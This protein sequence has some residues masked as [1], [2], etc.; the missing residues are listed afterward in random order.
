MCFPFS[1]QRPTPNPFLGAW[2]LSNNLLTKLYAESQ[3]HLQA[4]L[5]SVDR[6]CITICM[7]AWTDAQKHSVIVF[8]VLI[9]GHKPMLLEALD[10]SYDSHTAEH[11]AHLLKKHVDRVGKNK[12]AAI[13]TDNPSANR[14]A[15]VQVV[16]MQGYN[17][18]LD[19]RCM[20]H[21]FA[22]II[23][24]ITSHPWAREVVVKA[25]RLITFMRA[26]HQPL[27][28]LR[29]HAAQVN[30]KT[31]LRQPNKTRFTSL[32]LA[33]E[34]L[35]A[36]QPAF[37]VFRSQPD[38]FNTIS[39]KGADVKDIIR[40]NGF[41]DQAE[42]LLKVLQPLSQVIMAVQS[43]TTILADITR[44]WLYLARTY[45]A[46]L[47][48]MPEHAAGF[49]LHVAEQYNKRA[50]ELASPLCRL[51]LFL[52]PRYRSAAVAASTP[53][54]MDEL[55]ITAGKIMKAYGNSAAR[56]QAALDQMEDYTSARGVFGRAI[57]MRTFNLS[58]WWRSVQDTS[59]EPLVALALLLAEVVPHA[60]SPECVFSTMGWFEGGRRSSL[61]NT[62]NKQLTAVKMYLDSK[63]PAKQLSEKEAAAAEARRQRAMQVPEGS[64]EQATAAEAAAKAA[65]EAAAEAAAAGDEGEWAPVS[66]EE[67]RAGLER[68]YAYAQ[69]QGDPV[70]LE[71][72]RSYTE[73]LL[74]NWDGFDMR[75]AVFEHCDLT[76]TQ[77]T[78]PSMFGAGEEG[79]FDVEVLVQ[80][81]RG[82]PAAPAPGV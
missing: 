26:S 17:H 4:T 79:D 75:A 19:L 44:Y 61:S 21:G 41:W 29:E 11:L 48:S 14:S 77:P 72:P 24:N 35:L 12:V 15:R 33:L 36:L 52:D 78:V 20:M 22:L 68:M 40:D 46:L 63:L 67:M 23:G 47:P 56:V 18:I 60:A 50:K 54:K 55:M 30:I 39:A 66:A 6:P 1:Q 32:C 43:T 80:S 70:G 10:G 58:S 74:G 76:P 37:L 73:L 25:T 71:P 7:D 16:S 2:K 57:D 51:A 42:L 5:D 62:T 64:S 28:R 9:P 3:A 45:D 49:A 69:Q 65:A 82:Q 34:A 27:A 8:T 59:N 81:R 53:E 38:S 31:G 13:C